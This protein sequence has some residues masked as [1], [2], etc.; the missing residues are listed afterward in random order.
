MLTLEYFALKSPVVYV[1]SPSTLDAN[2]FRDRG[3][4]CLNGPRL[5]M[6][7]KEIDLVDSNI[8]KYFLMN[9]III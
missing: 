7:S 3:Q 8:L 6:Y 1:E 5:L 4:G 2:V 9:V